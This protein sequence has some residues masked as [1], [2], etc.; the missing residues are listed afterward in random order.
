MQTV[1]VDTAPRDLLTIEQFAERFPAWTQASLR[2]LILN[3]DDRLS[4]RGPIPGNGLSP[5]IFRD[6]RRVLISEGR[7]FTWLA[8]QQRQRRTA[9]G[10][11]AA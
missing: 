6:R 11:K 7:F 4:S 3:A 5:A 2:N 1:E 10:R 8:L 9:R